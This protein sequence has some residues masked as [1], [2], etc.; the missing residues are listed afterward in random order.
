MPLRIALISSIF[1]VAVPC[2]PTTI[3]AAWFATLIDSFVFNPETEAN[4]KVAIKVSPAPVTS[5]TFFAFA[6][7]N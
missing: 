7:T 2:F 1:V 6:G 5:I 4:A 3:P